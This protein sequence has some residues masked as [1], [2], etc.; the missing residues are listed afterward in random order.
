MQTDM[1]GKVVHWANSHWL[2]QNLAL[3]F[4]LIFLIQFPKHYSLSEWN[5]CFL[6]LNAFYIAALSQSELWSHAVMTLHVYDYHH[7]PYQEY[8]GYLN[9]VYMCFILC[10]D[11]QLNMH[12]KTSAPSL[13]ACLSPPHYVRPPALNTEKL[14]ILMSLTFWKR[15]CLCIFPW[16]RPVHTWNILLNSFSTYSFKEVNNSQKFHIF[17][18]TDC[19]LFRW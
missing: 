12:R 8:M 14:K 6:S 13:F 2:I 9:L 5:M 17:L 15:I 16:R 11:G 18:A 10:V 19:S 7:C 4:P 1:T 3:E